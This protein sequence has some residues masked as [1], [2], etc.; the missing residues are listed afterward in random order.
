MTGDTLAITPYT[1]VVPPTSESS[2]FAILRR[3][4]SNK[5]Q[6]PSYSRTSC[7]ER[8]TNSKLCLRPLLAVLFLLSVAVTVISSAEVVPRVSGLQ[9]ISVGAKD[10]A[11]NRVP[12]VISRSEE[13]RVGK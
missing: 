4:M 3:I 13:R 5:L 7:G 6:P 12:I 1:T 10:S 8:S 11:T 9:L 2:Y